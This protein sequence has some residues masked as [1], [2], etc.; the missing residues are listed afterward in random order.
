MSMNTN[1]F[2]LTGPTG[3]GKSHLLKKWK[4]KAADKMLLLDPLATDVNTWESPVPGTVELVAI[5]H[6]VYLRR[7]DKFCKQV[8][9][10]ATPNNVLVIL[11]ADRLRDLVANDIALPADVIAM[12]LVGRAGEDGLMLTHQGRQIHVTREDIESEF[13]VGDEPP[14]IPDSDIDAG[15]DEDGSDE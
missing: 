13:N 1:V 5:D 12:E 14:A 8:I 7:S 3:Q 11:V 4:D 15:S 10:W 2:V 9:D 6:T